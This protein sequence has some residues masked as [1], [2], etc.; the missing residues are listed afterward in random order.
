MEDGGVRPHGVGNL[1]RELRSG[2]ED[3]TVAGDEGAAMAFNVREGA[4][5]IELR[6]EDRVRG[7]RTARGCG[8]AALG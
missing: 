5:S 8:G 2:L 6:L 7:G 4:E 1:L 3:V